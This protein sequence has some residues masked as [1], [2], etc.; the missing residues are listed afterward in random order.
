MTDTKAPLT[1]KQCKAARGLLGWSQ[2]KL[3]NEVGVTRKTIY[4]FE[5]GETRT[6]PDTL[7]KMRR[8][9]EKAGLEVLEPGQNPGPG[10]SGIRWRD[11]RR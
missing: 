7:K 1:A 11:R 10:G 8:A 5:H 6:E 9:F 4:N 2:T 3:A